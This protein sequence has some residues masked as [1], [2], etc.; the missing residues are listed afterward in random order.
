MEKYLGIDVGG[1]YIKLGIVSTQGEILSRYKVAVDASGREP[2]MNTIMEAVGHFCSESGI[3]AG[4]LQGIG[5]SA[6]GSVDSVN[7]RIAINGGNVPGWPGTDVCDVLR[8]EFKVPVSLAN[9]GNCA[10]LGEAWQG[11]AKGFSDVVCI[12]LGTGIGGGIITGGRLVTGASGFAGEIGHFPT[13]AGQ[14]DVCECGRR[15]C[16][17]R[18]ASTSALTRR[19]MALDEDLREGHKVFA[20]IE[21]GRSDV[22]AILDEW[23]DEVAYGIA[24]LV[25]I[26]NPEIVL[27]GGGVSAQEERVI[28]PVE[29]RVRR[30]AM[31]DFTQD[32]IIRGASLGND[33]GLIGAVRFL[34]D[35]CGGRPE[36]AER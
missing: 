21:A 8:S 35:S 14:G 33:A 15:G 5:V 22:G 18:F 24:G 12:T 17:E 6:P 25:H 20:A 9:D 11:A 19:T 28:K 10:A 26:F 1:T 16:Y 29:E 27:I 36:D 13:H 23:L 34:I 2:V 4:L 7:G 3:P 30:F 32:L 31:P